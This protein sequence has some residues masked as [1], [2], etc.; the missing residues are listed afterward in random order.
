MMGTVLVLIHIG[1]EYLVYE[2]YS[3]FGLSVH[4]SLVSGNHFTRKVV[5]LYKSSSASTQFMHGGHLV[6]KSH[7]E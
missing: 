4:S 6:A 2:I 3:F 5:L 1:I 7:A